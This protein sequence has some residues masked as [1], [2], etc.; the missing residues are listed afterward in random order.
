MERYRLGGV[1]VAPTDKT[2]KVRTGKAGQP[3]AIAAGP[4]YSQV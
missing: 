1:E 2:L 3:G 4:A